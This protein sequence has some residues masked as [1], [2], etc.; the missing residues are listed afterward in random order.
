LVEQSERT[1]TALVQSSTVLKET[2]SGFSH[3]AATIKSSGKLL[4]KYARRET[5]DKILI[6]L[7]LF[8]YFGVIFY[9]LKKRL[10]VDW[11]YI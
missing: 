9:I 4:S 2:H 7:A 5:T 10:P 8:F 6:A 1:T 11:L 3:L